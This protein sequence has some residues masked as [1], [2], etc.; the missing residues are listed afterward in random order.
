[1]DKFKVLLADDDATARYL[2]QAALEKA[3]FGVILACDGE[4]AIH[5]FEKTPADMVML[6]VE[7]PFKDGYEVCSYL[8]KKVGNELPIV[9]VT[10]MD[11]TESID[12]AFNVGATFF[13]SKP[14]NWSLI[15]YR[16]LYLKRTYLNQLKLK[17]ANARNKAIFSAI[18]DEIFILTDDGKV[19]DT[20]NTFAHSSQTSWFKSKQGEALNQSLP[21]E[22]VKTYLG[23]IN[24]ARTN[25][26]TENFE[27]QFKLN[28]QENRHYECRTVVIDSHETLCL[29]RDITD[30]KNSESRIFRLAYF[31]NLTGLPNR[32]SFM[33]RLKREIKRAKFTNTRLA[34][35]FLDLDGFKSIND[36]MGHSTG[37]LILKWAAERI[38][39]SIRSSDIL[40]RSHAAELDIEFARLGGDE[41]T[42]AVP[43][44]PYVEDALILAHR[45]RDAMRHPF[46]LENRNVVLTASIGIALYPDDGE[47]VETL[48]KHADTAM[49]HAKNEG[50]DNCQFYSEA[51]TKQAETRLTLENDLRN[52]MLQNEFQLVYQPLFDVANNSIQSVEAL[53]RWQH[54]TQ[55]LISPLEFIPLAE[56]NGLI[57]PIGEWVLRTACTEAAQWQKSGQC[58]RMAVNLSPIQF[59]NPNLVQSVLNILAETGFPPDKLTLEI[60][61]GALMNYSAE[62]LETLKTLRDHKIRI[63]LDDFGTGYSSMSYL[64]QLPIHTIK[65]DQ[66]FIRSMLDDKDS[67]SIVRAII[68]LSKNLGFTL[69][70]E[71]IEMLGQAQALKFLGCETLQGYYFSK[72]INGREILAFCEKQWSI[73]AVEPIEK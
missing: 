11:N 34:I 24:R 63:A 62:T 67:L 55:G 44:L 26:T 9:M 27:Y 21:E 39:N 50:R 58:L 36:T 16:I 13:I 42:V 35:L 4:E 46:Q 73:Q 72:P 1:M 54:P 61:E 20:C 43:N 8:R 64:K 56:E 69:T 18:P 2:M 47:D 59:K 40:S 41:F 10:G 37:D 15:H 14:I 57:I 29:V 33:E 12:R 31:D 32:Q 60:T 17:V 6:D 52:A 51:L 65:V 38:K 71:G 48:V 28:E 25:S 49:H 23:A 53:I 5:L 30:R 3:G 45:I 66:I 68:S 22:I 7:M 19:V 70:A